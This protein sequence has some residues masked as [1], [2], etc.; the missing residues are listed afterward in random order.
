MVL[1][2][3]VGAENWKPSPREVLL[4]T[5]P[6]PQPLKS[7]FQWTSSSLKEHMSIGSDSESILYLTIEVS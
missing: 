6:S 3:P 1:S 7:Q 5:E 2:C 4:T